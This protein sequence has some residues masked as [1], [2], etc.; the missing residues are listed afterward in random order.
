MSSRDRLRPP[1]KGIPGMLRLPE[2]VVREIC[3][4]LHPRHIGALRGASRDL[5][6][7]VQ[8]SFIETFKTIEIHLDKVHLAYLKGL[9]RTTLADSVQVVH[10]R[11]RYTSSPLRKWW[12]SEQEK[13]PT[14][15]ELYASSGSDV[16]HL[17]QALVRF[18]NLVRIEV[19]ASPLPALSSSLVVNKHQNSRNTIKRDNVHITGMTHAFEAVLRAMADGV[20][21]REIR[22]GTTPHGEIRKSIDHR[23]LQ[24]PKNP[25]SLL[26]S[27]R[28]LQ[29]LDLVLEGQ[30]GYHGPGCDALLAKFLEHA[31]NV[32]HL[33]LSF[34]HMA[35]DRLSQTFREVTLPHLQT[36]DLEAAH[37]VDFEPFAHFL[38]R[39]QPSL[40]ELELKNIIFI[41]D[42]LAEVFPIKFLSG[43]L[44]LRHINFRQLCSMRS[45][46]LL[47]GTNA[48]YVCSVCD[49]DSRAIFFNKTGPGCEHSSL[50][51]TEGEVSANYQLKRMETT[52]TLPWPI[53]VSEPTSG[54]APRAF[55]WEW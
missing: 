16:K 32:R 6:N 42:R 29:K 4:H 54:S 33:K 3:R 44:F 49:E 5:K 8:P 36:L 20:V 45:G 38:A 46:M 40:R 51:A 27:L 31:T 22:A 9:S 34:W 50:V 47:F 7:T 15:A 52:C 13:P 35:G 12:Q 21:V 1:I 39:H 2:D 55:S 43:G 14:E 28:Q 24:L 11:P 18:K 26:P 23:A 53:R 10:F 48:D 25:Q 30:S 41:N 19:E 37:D 17:T